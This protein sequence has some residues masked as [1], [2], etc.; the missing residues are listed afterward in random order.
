MLFLPKVKRISHA[1]ALD[2][3][4]SS[5]A[6]HELWQTWIRLDSAGQDESFLHTWSGV[7]TSVLSVQH[8]G[9]GIKSSDSSQPLLTATQRLAGFHC[10]L[11]L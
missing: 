3:T 8:H 9:E 7:W 10:A 1:L 5:Q 11:C 6:L 2:M 4:H